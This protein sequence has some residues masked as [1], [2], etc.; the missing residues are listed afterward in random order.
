V[1][2]TARQVRDRKPD[3]V[4]WRCE[5]FGRLE[6]TQRRPFTEAELRGL[7]CAVAMGRHVGT[8]QEQYVSGL[9][10]RYHDEKRRLH[11]ERRAAAAAKHRGRM[12]SGA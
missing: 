3:D 11:E 6:R 12:G 8:L 9:W 7:R 10:A 1:S 5:N 2:P 4:C